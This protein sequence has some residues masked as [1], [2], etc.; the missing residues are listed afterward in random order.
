MRIGIIGYGSAGRRHA[1]NIRQLDPD[2]Q[3]YVYDPALTIGSET[4]GVTVVDAESFWDV[5][6]L[7]AVIIASPLDTHLHYLEAAS[8]AR[9][10]VYCEKPLCGPGQVE[11]WGAQPLTLSESAEALVGKLAGLPTAAGYNWLYHAGVKRMIRAGRHPRL[12][13]ASVRT[14]MGAWSGKSYGP[15]LW[16]CS[17][18]LAV[19]QAWLGPLTVTAAIPHGP[20]GGVAS[21]SAGE[22][23]WSFRW[24]TRAPTP[25]SRCYVVYD[26]DTPADSFKQFV[27]PPHG[28]DLDQSYR[29]AM[30]DFLFHARCS[31]TSRSGQT[32]CPLADGLVIAKLCEQIDQLNRAGTRV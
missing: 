5:L 4:H 7:E 22:V 30:S 29:L 15:P 2:A 8:F 11:T 6:G 14:D 16:E 23:R 13:C 1:A 28:T 10:P 3:L 19:L 26:D 9:L 24:C 27:F 31:G 18:E 17:H 20:H 25:H 32:N 21:G 12:V